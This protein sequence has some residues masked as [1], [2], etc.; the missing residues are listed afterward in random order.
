MFPMLRSLKIQK[1]H[2]MCF[3][4]HKIFPLAVT[5][6][7]DYFLMNQMF[8]LMMLMMLMT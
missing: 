1:K 3:V 2:K 8:L 7:K 6:A 4:Q 5:D